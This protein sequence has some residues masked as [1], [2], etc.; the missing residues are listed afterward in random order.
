MPN[1]VSNM[2]RKDALKSLLLNC[3]L[4]QQM[5]QV[6]QSRIVSYP[7]GRNKHHHVS[8]VGAL[9][10]RFMATQQSIPALLEVRLRLPGE[11]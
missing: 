10:K 8:A 1:M 9:P 2:C 3:V 7:V 4:Y 11:Q 6:S 5:Q